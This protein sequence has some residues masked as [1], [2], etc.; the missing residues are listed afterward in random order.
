MKNNLEDKLFVL[1]LSLK[2]LL[3]HLEENALI[4]V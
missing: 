1:P 4:A 3:L 2:N